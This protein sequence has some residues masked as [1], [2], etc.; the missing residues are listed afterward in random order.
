[1]MQARQGD[2]L[3]C[4]VPAIPTTAK[5]QD[6]CVLALGEATGHAHRINAGATLFLDE[7]ERKYFHVNDPP[8]VGPLPATLLSDAE[9]SFLVATALGTIRFDKQAAVYH[10]GLVETPPFALLEHEEHHCE[11]YPE[12]F[13]AVIQQQEYTPR[14]IRHVTD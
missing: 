6:Q 4:S 9:T 2:M 14:E 10:A 7:D 3:I 11:A 5:R 13:Y 8:H 12:G 1:M